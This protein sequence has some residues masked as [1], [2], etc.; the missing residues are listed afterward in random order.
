MSQ[1]T[2]TL[3]TDG[4][5]TGCEGL[6]IVCNDSGPGIRFATLINNKTEAMREAPV[7]YMKRN[8]FARLRFCPFC[9]TNLT[10][11]DPVQS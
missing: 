3:D 7:L 8:R 6:Q 11:K 5:V 4:N 2:C 9:G 10:P 1:D